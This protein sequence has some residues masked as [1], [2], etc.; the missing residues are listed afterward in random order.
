[1][2]LIHLQRLNAELQQVSASKTE[3]IANFRTKSN[4]WLTDASVLTESKHGLPELNVTLF[5]VKEWTKRLHQS[6]RN[7][8]IQSNVFEI[9][10]LINQCV[11]LLR[12]DSGRISGILKSYWVLF[13]GSMAL[14][15]ILLFISS[16]F[17]K[18][19]LQSAKALKMKQIELNG[20]VEQSEAQLQKL[21]SHLKPKLKELVH[22]QKKVLLTSLN[23]FQINLVRSSKTELQQMLYKVIALE[24]DDAFQDEYKVQ[25]KRMEMFDFAEQLYP[26]LRHKAERLPDGF[27]Y[28]LDENLPLHVSSDE[29]LLRKTILIVTGHLLEEAKPDHGLSMIVKPRGDKIEWLFEIGDHSTKLNGEGTVVSSD[30]KHLEATGLLFAAQL[31]GLLSGQIE[32]HENLGSIQSLSLV[33][34]HAQRQG[35]LKD[36]QIFQPE[37]LLEGYTIHLAP[38]LI[39]LKPSLETLIPIWRLQ[40]VVIHASLHSMTNIDINRS[41]LILVSESSASLDRDSYDTLLQK[42]QQE[43][44]CLYIVEKDPKEEYMAENVNI[45]GYVK[46]LSAQI[47]QVGLYRKLVSAL[48]DPVELRPL[49]ERFPFNILVISSDDVRNR[50]LATSFARLGFSPHF[51]SDGFDTVHLLSKQAYQMV[52]VDLSDQKTDLVGLVRN[53]PNGDVPVLVAI[54]D[55]ASSNWQTLESETTINHFI[56]HVPNTVE[57][58]EI[59]ENWGVRIFAVKETLKNRHLGELA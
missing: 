13:Y 49:S 7:E 19:W 34:E 54:S 1:M 20:D 30:M 6:S 9:Q 21:L 59:I 32:I 27:S 25:L 11:G 46:F 44:K 8:E 38:S 41:N 4:K 18:K 37:L 28:R 47:S 43:S 55:H 48:P 36:T 29:T 42:H 23:D 50:K 39:F 35:S 17:L 16:H 22:E 57:L 53:Q 45:G 10:K 40:S 14:V 15:V 31:A 24:G 52:L 3:E 51:A 56:Q 26:I 5:K 12:Q 58:Q 33:F 2:A